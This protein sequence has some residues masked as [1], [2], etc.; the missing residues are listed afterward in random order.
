MKDISIPKLQRGEERGGRGGG[1]RGALVEDE[2]VYPS[3]KRFYLQVQKRH[4]TA[5]NGTNQDFIN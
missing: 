2:Q 4:G 1:G 5:L 3:L